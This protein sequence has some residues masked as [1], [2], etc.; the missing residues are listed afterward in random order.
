MLSHS[1]MDELKF[2]CLPHRAIRDPLDSIVSTIKLHQSC[3]Q[4]VGSNLANP[5][6][7]IDAGFHITF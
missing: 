6:A 1:R 4:R 5:Y 3:R 2:T 7:H